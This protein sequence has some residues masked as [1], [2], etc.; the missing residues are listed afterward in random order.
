MYSPI[1]YV[2]M[3]TNSFLILFYYTGNPHLYERNILLRVS[4]QIYWELVVLEAF[5]IVQSEITN[6]PS[7]HDY[8]SIEA[9]IRKSSQFTRFI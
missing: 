1:S 9:F 3:Y 4:I 8:H 5:Q 7:K 6:T 2:D